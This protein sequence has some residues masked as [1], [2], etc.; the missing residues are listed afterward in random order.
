MRYNY[1]ATS[2]SGSQ[3]R[4]VIEAKNKREA[5]DKLAKQGFLD[6]SI[7]IDF[8]EF[9]KKQWASIGWI[10]Q[11]E[12]MMFTKHLSVMMKAQLSLDEA[13]SALKDQSTNP[14]MKN[15][16][17]AIL[18]GIESGKPLSDSLELFPRTF[19][20][21]YVNIVRAGEKSGKLENSLDNL[22]GSLNKSY[23]LRQKVKSAMIYPAIV[24]FLAL[25]MGFYIAF[26][27][28]P[29]ITKLFSSFKVK[30][31]WVTRALIFIANFLQ[32]YGLYL[33][34]G[35]IGLIILGIFLMRYEEVKKQVDRWLLKVPIFGRLIANFNLGLFARILAT[36]LQSGIPIVEALEISSK[37]FN[38][39]VY[40]RTLASCQLDVLK[41][42]NL[43][44]ALQKFPDNY[45]SI[46]TKMIAVGEET[47]KL[48]DVLLYLAE[49]FESEVDYSTKNLSYILEPVLLIFVGVVMA[50]IA[51][52]IILPIYQITASL[53]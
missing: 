34:L 42:M 15:V 50:I 38:N 3:I 22:A 46:V 29:R 53:T 26:F 28:L 18:R 10:S 41:G 51:L 16:L 43:S 30:L 47:G 4:G 48:E 37:T 1:S 19:E 23:E 27:I 5:E 35:I 25:G 17:S 40:Q 8:K 24:L 13:V 2:H 9:I 32:D 21:L 6:V 45:P 52:A 36:L 20:D 33:I 39:R 31:P 49:F 44:L 11:V 7:R 12:K 14:K